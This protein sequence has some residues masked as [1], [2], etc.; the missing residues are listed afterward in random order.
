MLTF[1]NDN[2]RGVVV[3]CFGYFEMGT[4]VEDGDYLIPKV[5]DSL[6]GGRHLRNCV[7]RHHAEYFF[8][9]QDRN[10]IVFSREGEGEVFPFSQILGLGYGLL[11]CRGCVGHGVTCMMVVRGLQ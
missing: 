10:A 5:D 9:L 11:G 4:H 1:D 2:A 3:G 7:D 8:D 6:D